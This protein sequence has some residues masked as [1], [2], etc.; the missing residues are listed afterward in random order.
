[1]SIALTE[2]EVKFSSRE[3]Q[4]R[5]LEAA[6]ELGAIKRPASVS[7]RA[8]ENL[9]NRYLQLVT[10]QPL[11]Q[12]VL[13]LQE[14]WWCYHGRCSRGGVNGS[15][16]EDKTTADGLEIR[17]SFLLTYINKYSSSRYGTLAVLP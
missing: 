13:Y 14:G 5:F 2:D 15:G 1:M 7:V 10:R 3:T 8:T 4:T 6:E 12:V 17:G 9:L 11:H 16:G